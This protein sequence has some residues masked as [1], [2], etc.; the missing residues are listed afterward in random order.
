LIPEK[1]KQQTNGNTTLIHFD[2]TVLRD[3]DGDRCVLCLC[4]D[5]DEWSWDYDYLE[6]GFEA[7][8]PSAVLASPQ[9]SVA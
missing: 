2:G 3:S 7:D 6:D 4:W 1:W 5:G 9:N 8:D